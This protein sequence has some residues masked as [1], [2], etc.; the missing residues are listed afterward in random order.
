[1][2]AVSDFAA[3]SRLRHLRPARRGASAFEVMWRT[4]ELVTTP[5]ATGEPP[6]REQF[7][8]TLVESLGSDLARDA[9]TSR[10]AAGAAGDGPSARRGHRPLARERE[11]FWHPRGCRGAALPADLRPDVSA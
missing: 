10:R 4:P 3:G 11:A 7:R 2:V 5:P 8:T 9:R 1:M 6:F